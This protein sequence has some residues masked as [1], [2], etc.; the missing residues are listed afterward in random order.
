MYIDPT[1]F[2]EITTTNSPIIGQPLMLQCSATIMRDITSSVDIIWTD[3]SNAQVRRVN[4]IAASNIDTLTV[5]NDIFVIPSL[6][7]S[8]IGSIYQC[9]VVIYSSPPIMAKDDFTISFLSAGMY[10]II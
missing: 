7:I 5:Y 10:A 6:D 4:N 8:D 2:L 1:I 3:G 9:E